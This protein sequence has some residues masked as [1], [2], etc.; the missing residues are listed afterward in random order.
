MGKEIGRNAKKS[1]PC[2]SLVFYFS[3]FFCGCKQP[4]SVHIVKS[5]TKVRISERKAKRKAKKICFIRFY[6]RFSE[7]EYLRRQSKVR[8][9][10]PLQLA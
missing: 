7:P 5:P 10:E 9:S 2:G 4:K 3:I 1:L 6:V 8:I